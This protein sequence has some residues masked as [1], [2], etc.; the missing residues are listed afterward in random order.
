MREQDHLFPAELGIRNVVCDHIIPYFA[1][2]PP[3]FLAPDKREGGGLGQ[4]PLPQDRY[5]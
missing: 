2:L 3:L 1:C 4:A 5:A